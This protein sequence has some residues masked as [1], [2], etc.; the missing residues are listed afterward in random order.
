MC[1]H[2]DKSQPEREWVLKEFRSGK[3]P[4]LIATDVASRGL[5]IPDINFVV[6]YDYPNSGE[7]YIHRIGRTAR[8]SK[9]GTAYTF[10]TA[11]NGKNASELI[12]VMQEAHQTVPPKLMDLGGSSYGGRKRMR[13]SSESDDRKY[14]QK[15]PNSYGGGGG[16]SA[17]KRS[18]PD[19]GGNRPS[20]L[21]GGSS[22]N[23]G[24]NRDSRPN[25]GSHNQGGGQN[26][27]NGGNNSWNNA[28]QQQ[29]QQQQSNH[30]GSW[31][32]N[33]QSNQS[34]TP[35]NNGGA[36]PGGAPSSGSAQEQWAQYHR[37]MREWEQKNAEWQ[38]WQQN[39]GSGPAAPA[40]M[41]NGGGP[42]KPNNGY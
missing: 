2:G 8:A 42:P 3:A 6:N 40:A 32:Q 28:P 24:Y 17:S 34:N 23:G 13:F 36:P 15:R 4:V 7:D 1:I 20:P 12:A 26:Q 5:D 14:G 29:Q 37:E 41:T 9:T 39:S 16:G 21:M 19:H 22:S 31:N 27:W 10:F 25:G 33:A 11:A 18:A 38:K 35:N 30:G